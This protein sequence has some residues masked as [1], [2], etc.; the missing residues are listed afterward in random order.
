M[1]RYRPSE[2][3]PC[4]AAPAEGD[5]RLVL[6]VALSLSSFGQLYKTSLLPPVEGEKAYCRI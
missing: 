1:L 6:C 5:R 2:I 3:D 4:A